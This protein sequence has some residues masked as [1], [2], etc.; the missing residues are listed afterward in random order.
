MNVQS[1]KSGVGKDCRNWELYLGDELPVAS[2]SFGSLDD[3]VLNEEPRNNTDKHEGKE[4]NA[5]RIGTAEINLYI[6]ER[7][8]S[9]G[10]REP[11]DKDCKRGLY[12]GPERTDNGALVHLDKFLFG[13]QKNLLAKA[14]VFV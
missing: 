3:A 4:I 2:Q 6:S 11:V 5:E 10:K 9:Y 12:N 1:G 7:S 13:E 8:D 14:L